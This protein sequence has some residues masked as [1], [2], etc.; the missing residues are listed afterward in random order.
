MSAKGALLSLGV[1][2]VFLAVFVPLVLRVRSG[3]DRALD[4][5][6]LRRTYVGLAL[7]ESEHDGLPAPN[8]NLVRRDVETVDL[9]S[10]DDPEAGLSKSRAYPLDPFRP[11]LPLRSPSRVSWSYRYHWPE[12][13]DPRTTSL[14]RRCGL[15]ADPWPGTLLRVMMD[16]AM[17]EKPRGEA[18]FRDLFG[19]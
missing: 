4:A 15:L 1:V 6:R 18:T 2:V 10:V 7:Y 16:G 8:L 17:V 14:D 13:G 12:A 9:T 3:R 11:D 19:Q 5:E